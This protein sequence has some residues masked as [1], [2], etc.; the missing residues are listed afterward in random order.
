M[1]D[2]ELKKI[3]EYHKILLKNPQSP[4]FAMLAECYRKAGRLEEALDVTR[5]GLEHK[6]DFVS[7][8]VVHSRILFD[9]KEYKL[10][11]ESFKKSLE[12]SPKNLLSLRFIAF[13]YLKIG[14]NEQAVDYIKKLLAFNPNDK[15]ALELAKQFELLDSESKNNEKN[16]K[17]MKAVEQFKPF[18]ISGSMEKKTHSELKEQDKNNLG[19]FFNFSTNEKSNEKASALV[20]LQNRKDFY[21]RCLQ[22]IVQGVDSLRR[23]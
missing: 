4:L 21:Q 12:L 16:K 5:K 1:D 8:L 2:R 10:A 18:E 17:D 7:G 6:P 11:I 14:Q 19:D 13:C 20:E 3:Q 9:L 22:R 15:E 23:S